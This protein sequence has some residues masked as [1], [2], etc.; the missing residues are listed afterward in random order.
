MENSTSDLSRLAS[1]LYYAS[2]QHTRQRRKDEEQSPYINHPISLLHLLAV[3]AGVLDADVLCAG[4]LHDLI[5]DFAK[6]A[7]ERALGAAEIGRLFG[8]PGFAIVQE[9][10]DAKEP[11][12]AKRKSR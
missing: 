11:P 3:E 4:V 7:D 5:E 2:Q 1:A 8:A 6:T 9:G 12:E 10:T